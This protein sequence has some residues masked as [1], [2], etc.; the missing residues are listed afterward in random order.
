MTKR[1]VVSQEAIE[2]LCE[3]YGLETILEMNGIEPHIVIDLLINEG[4]IDLDEFSW[5]TE[6]ED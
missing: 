3:D 5:E 2:N 6:D 1:I 4:L